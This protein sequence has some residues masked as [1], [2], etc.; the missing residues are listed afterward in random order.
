MAA[1][2]EMRN[3]YKIGQVMASIVGT[4][5]FIIICKFGKKHFTYFRYIFYVQGKL[6]IKLFKDIFLSFIGYVTFKEMG[7]EP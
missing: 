7:R 2:E 4:A 6:I 5:I 1:I 3:S